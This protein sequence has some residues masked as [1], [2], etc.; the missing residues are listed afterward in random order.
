[1]TYEKLLQTLKQSQIIIDERH[2]HQ[3][4]EFAN[5]AHAGQ[6]RLSG[7][8]YITHPLSVARILAQWKQ[9]QIVIEAAILHDT[10][11]DT[12]VTL[13][14]I[15]KQFGSEIAFLVD[16]VSK[17]SQVKI[18]NK[19]KLTH[20]E[21]LQKMFVAMAKDIRVI[22]IKLADRYH[23]L[24]TLDALPEAKRK[25]IAHNTIEIYAPLAE[26]LGMGKIKG[27]LEDLSFPH[28]RPKSYSWVIKVAKEH[29]E[30]AEKITKDTIK[31]L[32]KI[33]SNNKLNTQINGRPKHKY[34]LYKKLTRKDINKDFSKIHD[35]IALRVIT[36]NKTDCYTCLGLIHN[37]FKPVPHL[38]VSDFIAQ[39]KPN[40]YQSIHTKVFDHHGRIIE[41]QIRSQIM[42][43]Q[44][45]YGAAAHCLYSD[46]KNQQGID[47]D[48]IDKTISYGNQNNNWLTELA[49]W[50]NQINNPNEF[51][52]NLKL[53][54]LCHRIY[55]YTPNGDVI[56]L[57]IDSTPVDFAFAIHG[58][59]GFYIQAAKVDQKIV[60]L[61]RKL[62]SGDVVEIIKSKN[63]RH[64]S[65]EWLRFVKTAKARS[66][67]KKILAKIDQSS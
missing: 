5:K 56:D 55:V 17:V 46:I 39:P 43:H 16:G 13:S 14:D 61:D 8:D 49:N 18:K 50:Q 66:E 4:F 29:F 48:K 51:I 11:E 31:E 25:H 47:Q 30:I 2:L 62:K 23:N 38:G 59:L 52:D 19:L 37:H 3:V 42:H 6:K 45:E 44:A 58:D 12:H 64:P 40:G 9:P 57:P 7:E 67:I 24:I 27:E 28:V 15:E 54:A 10:V 21:T 26:R 32:K 20:I 33:L 53:D 36:R 65:R 34:S 22:M 1:M 35:L 60:T 63:R 41:I